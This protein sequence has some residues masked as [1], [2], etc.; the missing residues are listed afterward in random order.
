MIRVTLA[1]GL[2]LAPVLCAAQLG[3]PNVP[4]QKQFVSFAGAPAVT[5]KLGEVGHADLRFQVARGD[6]INS[7]QPGSELLIPTKLSL[8]AP[9][10]IL[11]GDV[12]YPPGKA[13][14]LA[15]APDEKLSVYSGEFTVA[16]S[17][18]PTRKTTPG[19]Y[20]VHGQLRYQA[21]SD[22]ACYPPQNLPVE[23]DVKVLKSTGNR[24]HR[25]PP[26]TPHAHP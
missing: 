23:F 22:R 2:L 10:E 18:T 12:T 11:V 7:N 8:S 5:I 6:H 4:G 3:S 1:S 24:G 17:L 25:N 19:N 14:T 15:I 9:G 26:Q 21:C 20:R 16:A 13:Y